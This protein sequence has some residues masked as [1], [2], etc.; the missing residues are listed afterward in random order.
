MMIEREKKW[1]TLSGPWG[2]KRKGSAKRRLLFGSSLNS[3]NARCR[4]TRSMKRLLLGVDGWAQCR[5]I[6]LTGFLFVL[7]GSVDAQEIVDHWRYQVRRPAENWK[8]TNFDDSDWTQGSAGFGT[9]GTPGARVGTNWATNSI[10]MRKRFNLESIPENPALLIHHDE[11]A[12]VYINGKSVAVLKGYTSQYIT[13]SIPKEKQAALKVG[14]NVMAVHCRQ[15]IGGQFIDVHL[16]D[17]DDVPK[18]PPAKRNTK[19][20][21]SQL[22]TKW[23]EKVTSDNAWTEYPRPMLVR[24]DWQ[25]LNGHWDYAV[26]PVEQADVPKEWSGEILVPYCL[27]SKLG[28]VG[29]LLD[30][31]EALWYRRSFDLSHSPSQR[32]LLNFEALDYRC[33]VFVNGKSVGTHQGGNTPFYFDVSAS[34]INGKNGLIVRVEDE[35]EGWQLRGKQVLNARG[36]WY[37]QVSGIWQTVWLEQV[38]ASGSIEDLKI[39]TDAETGSI[40]VRPVV[41]GT[42]DGQVTVVIKDGE[43]EIASRVARGDE[44][45]EVVVH[46]A[47]LWSP[48]NPH[49][50][51][52]E[53]T[54]KGATGEVLDRVTSYAGIRTLGKSQDKDGHWRF[55]LNGEP[56]FHWGPLDQGWWPDGLLTPPSDEAMLFDIEFLK[57]AGFNM[58]RKHIKVEPRRY[59]YHCDRL[60]MMVWQDHVSGGEKPP[61][62]RLKPNPMD[63]QW[64]DAQHRQFMLELDRM[65]DALENHPSITVW[66]P[67]NEAWGQ[68]RTVDVGKWTVKRDPTRPINIAS[69]GNFWPVGDIV[70]AHSYPNPQFPYDSNRFENFI[71][72]EGEFG[73]H[74]YPVKGHLWDANRRNWG[75]GGLPQTSAEYKERYVVSL[76]MLNEMRGQGIAA[77]VYT[78]TTDVEGEINGL[79]TYDRKVI[80][81][82]ASDLK[83][84]HKILFLDLAK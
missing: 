3:W 17:A 18:L 22:I 77:G 70:D 53:V 20:F 40:R 43:T 44:A 35:T 58:I 29:R 13:V 66:V 38:S 68:H 30:A 65:I 49:L 21:S 81:I 56:I 10:W 2:S 9:I 31:S 54:L 63:A 47:K 23:G 52:L 64:P 74:G 83:E 46:G 27:E 60:G 4:A 55:T 61:W 75:Y 33:E 79:M 15:T 84:L 71:K 37:T 69:G 39:T 24:R 19:P 67:F 12:E 8:Q 6:F 5:R 16:V 32:T 72:V 36:I 73:G 48:S 57:A 78:Q 42:N 82:Q 11:G 80:K 14:V 34:V 7:C 26:T 62:T 28:G 41:H 59:Y 25:N 76:N 50:Y 51:D 1:N 45:I